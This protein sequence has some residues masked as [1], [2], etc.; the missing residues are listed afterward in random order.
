MNP[1]VEPVFLTSLLPTALEAVEQFSA[2]EARY[3]ELSV[4]S[5]PQHFAPADR[6]AVDALKQ[7]LGRTGVE[8]FSVHAS[9]GA[10]VDLS[11]PESAI[12]QHAV[13]THLAEMRLAA[14]LRA[15]AVVVHPVGS[16]CPDASQRADRL[17]ASAASLS[18]LAD[19]A[20]DLGLNLAV[21]NMT[22]HNPADDLGEL[23][24]L[25]DGLNCPRAGFCFDTGHCH[26][27][28]IALS[29][30]ISA[31]A[32]RLHVIH[33]HDN[34]G[35]RDEHLNPGAGNIDWEDYYAG[36]AGIGFDAP[37]TVEAGNRGMILSEFVRVAKLA[38]DER[39]AMYV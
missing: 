27:N 23:V 7:A 18:A 14:E 5:G 19:A 21:E 25:V 1:S 2:A 31:F 17:A 35:E 12:R 4:F 8:V 9:F 13:A 30:M 37:V 15:Q 20:V 16:G 33:W 28:G 29:Q 10:A 6:D 22:P 36:L 34:N 26:L 11:S 24:A 39:R 3:L 32:G 38:L